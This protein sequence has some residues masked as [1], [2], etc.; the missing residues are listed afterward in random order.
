MQ[1]SKIKQ[2]SLAVCMVLTPLSVYA[3]G[4]GKLNT[5]SA[6]GEPLRAEIE[7]IATPEELASIAASIA[8]EEAFA[9]QGV[10]RLGIHNQIKVDLAKSAAGKSVLKLRSAEPVKD[11]F[12]DLIIQMDWAGGQLQREY[13]VLLDPPTYK[14]TEVNAE[15]VAVASPR[16]RANEEI[17]SPTTTAKKASTK[18][19]KK[20][21]KR[22]DATPKVDVDVAADAQTITTKSGDSLSAIAKDL[23]VEGVSL[24]QMLAG[25]YQANPDAFIK[26]NINRLKVGQIVKVPTK[27]SLAAIDNG[28]AKQI[29]KVHSANWNAYRNNVAKAVASSSVNSESD[30]KQTSSGKITTAEDKAAAIKV[31]PQ[32]VVKLSAGD[33]GTSTAEGKLT[34]LQEEAVAREKS[35][36][37]SQE[38]AA[39]L[40]AQIND[41]KKVL[42]LKNQAMADKQNVAANANTNTAASATQTAVVPE[43]KPADVAVETP[44]ASSTESVTAAASATAVAVEPKPTPEV[45]A[46]EVKPAPVA[47]E[48]P[49]VVAPPPVPVEEPSFLD[50]LLGGDSNLPLI[51]G[52]VGLALLG[53]GWMFLRNKRK[54]NLDSFERGILTSGG[55][56][57][58]T[59][60]GN[61]TSNTSTSDT[62]FL[63]DFAQSVDGG[64]IDTNDVDP[65]AEA[66]VYMAYGR[67]A[68]AE[69]ILKDAILKEPK[70]YEL[71]LKL[72][73]I[74]VE[75]K[76]AASFE[77]IAGE[78][79]TTLGAD[80]P[81]WAK[82]ATLGAKLEPDNPLYDLSKVAVTSAAVSQL[83]DTDIDFSQENTTEPVAAKADD[84]SED[85][86]SL[87]FTFD[88][89]PASA[90]E[91]GEHVETMLAHEDNQ[92]QEINFA[93]FEADD[94]LDIGGPAVEEAKP[95]VES[96]PH[97]EES[98]VMDFDLGG[99]LDVE[100]PKSNLELNVP[101]INTVLDEMPP[102]DLSLPE[103]NDSPSDVEAHTISADNA[104]VEALDFAMDFDLPS[105]TPTNEAANANEL[106]SDVVEQ[107]SSFSSDFSFDLPNED[108]LDLDIGES[109]TSDHLPVIDESAAP[110]FD[111]SSI[112]LDLDTPTI[113]PVSELEGVSEQSTKTD[114]ESPDVEI[115]LDLVAVYMDMDDKVGAR[116]LLEEVM[117]EGGANQKQR[118]Q[119]LLDSLA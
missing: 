19:I 26:G 55:L 112:S 41:M 71:H 97:V 60:F 37:E 101:E 27:E 11:P 63:T 15:A 100:E 117:K 91:A 103:K 6:L 96:A 1:I 5:Q 47:S 52:G 67:G 108:A 29:V 113:Q 2:I 57:A 64:M 38:R 90:S 107:K 49:H 88:E 7:V 50:S 104:P 75:N 65:I 61:T 79:Y 3:A 111:L 102:L 53:A 70:R 16:A 116:E 43:T 36:K 86:N 54:K 85:D 8:S 33:K 80:D 87:D 115:K 56:R 82:V 110:T 94:V 106:T 39:Q 40:E 31:G 23:Q 28:Q 24:D 81:I 12:L 73:E 45:K 72:L 76:D 14:A 48:K 118:A 93:E 99:L 21:K 44:S 51:G 22:A 84:F 4:L 92:A 17:S 89:E 83:S 25:L 68:Q 59:V 10:T 105:L 98:N 34:A 30:T 109:T 18:K 35:L 66:E 62:S 9:A 13:T 77:T 46:E 114:I 32:D 95:L 78:L 69:E 119:K 20:Y 74:Y 42:E 58:N